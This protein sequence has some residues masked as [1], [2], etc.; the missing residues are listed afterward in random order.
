MSINVN[1][2]KSVEIGCI[3]SVYTNK[4]LDSGPNNFI[5]DVKIMSVIRNHTSK[6]HD[7]TSMFSSKEKHS[8]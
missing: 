2:V 6:Q 3:L 5:D 4:K 1:E 7:Y 8:K